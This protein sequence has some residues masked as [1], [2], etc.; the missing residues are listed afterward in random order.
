M[1]GSVIS[2]VEKVPIDD[3]KNGYASLASF[4]ALD[5]DN[6]TFIYRKFDELSARN[7]LYLQ[8]ELLYL[9]R[10]LKRLDDEVR[11]TDDP[12]VQDAARTWEE[13]IRQVDDGEPNAQ[14]KMN[15]IIQM[16]AKIKE[17]R[18]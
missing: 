5:P 9:E 15:L 14:E 16:R 4:I 13:L 8:S 17:Y 12:D 1:Q 18:K 11:R 6:E 10:K 2:D 7:L 3:R